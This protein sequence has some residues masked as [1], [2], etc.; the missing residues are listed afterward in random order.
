M[1]DFDYI[2][3]RLD[4]QITWYSKESRKNKKRYSALNTIEIAL[5]VSIPILTSFVDQ[6]TLIKFAIALCGGLIAFIEGI[7]KI[8]NHKELWTKYRMT[9]E[10]LKRE[11]ILFISKSGPYHSSP[12]ISDLIVRCEKIMEEE[13][14][15]WIEL[16]SKKEKDA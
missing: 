8:Y 10:F 1:K 14:S 2:K 9:S 3:E 13:N 4:E 15:V 7:G 12:V 11:K 5:A 6:H 16:K